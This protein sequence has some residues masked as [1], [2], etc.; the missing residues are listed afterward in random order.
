MIGFAGARS[1]WPAMRSKAGASRNYLH[2]KGLMYRDAGAWHALMSRLAR[3]V[4]RYLN[5]Q[6]AAGAEAVQ[7]FDSWVGA[8]ARRLS[9]LCLAVY[10]AS[11]RHYARRA[12]DSLRRRQ[13]GLVAA[14]GR[15]RRRRDR[16][17]LARRL[18]MAWNRS[19][20]TGRAR[21]SRSGRALAEPDEI[22]RRAAR[23]STQAG[24][25]ARPHLQ[26]RTRHPSANAGRKRHRP[27]RNGSRAECQ[28]IR[29]RRFDLPFHPRGSTHDETSQEKQH[30][31]PVAAPASARGSL[32]WP[33]KVVAWRL[34]AGG[35]KTARWPPALRPARLCWFIRST[36][37]IGPAF[38]GCFAGP[39]PSWA[40][41][42]FWST[43][44]D[45]FLHRVMAD[46]EPET[47]DKVMAI[48][49]TGVFDCIRCVAARHAQARDGLIVNICS[50]A[51]LRA[52]ML[53][54]VAYCASKFAVSVFRPPWRW[55][56]AK[57]AFALP[58]FAPA[59]SRRRSWKAGRS[60]LRRSIEPKCFSPRTWPRPCDD[61]LLA[62]ACPH[63][64]AYHQA[65]RAG[66]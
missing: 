21:Q 64:R 11:S 4:T 12:G 58:A 23:C 62:P 46:I 27:G 41:S 6:I 36:W 7:L 17:R 54:G 52:S 34:P 53:G 39:R 37:P 9:P 5:A 63:C 29:R 61:R 3:G 35:R 44:P 26:P 65:G 40:R 1:R 2:T 50:T 8:S 47:W 43:V 51:D 19:A 22:R 28:V 32:G 59:R 31:L 18:D 42:T 14:G 66:F 56:K 38:E 30:S 48:N 25:P 33:P 15:S 60:N 13:S 45:Q 20:T 49:T 16:H 10:A 24:R 55:K 57:M